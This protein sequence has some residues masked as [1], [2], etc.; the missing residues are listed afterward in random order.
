MTIAIAP[1]FAFYSLA[2]RADF[3]R[4]E[5]CGIHYTIKHHSA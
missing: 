3:F 4:P 5:R 1:F 2:V